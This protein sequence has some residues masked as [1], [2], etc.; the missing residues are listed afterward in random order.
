MRGL[1][2]VGCVALMASLSLPAFAEYY[3]VYPVGGTS[4]Y[5][6][7]NY[8]YRTVPV[9]T[10]YVHKT[11]H[12]RHHYRPC[13]VFPHT[14]VQ[15][16]YVRPACG[17]SGCDSCGGYQPVY[18]QSTDFVTFNGQPEF[19]NYGAA[20]A[21][22]AYRRCRDMRYMSYDLRTGDDDMADLDLDR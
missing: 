17:C 5:T 4:T 12:Y 18:H 14:S 20:P 7:V 3:L 2:G 9:S 1:T 10:Q 21:P 15:M 6:G 11:Y 22:C 16:Q 19:V 13:R 8:I